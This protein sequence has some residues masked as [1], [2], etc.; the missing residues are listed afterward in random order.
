MGIS[1]EMAVD[2]RTDGGLG[3]SC[4]RQQT[5][6][7]KASRRT[8][9]SRTRIGGVGKMG[10]LIPRKTLSDFAILGIFLGFSQTNRISDNF[11]L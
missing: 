1:I 11:E 7:H 3:L 6:S 10:G 4:G 9:G 8:R 5:N 2:A